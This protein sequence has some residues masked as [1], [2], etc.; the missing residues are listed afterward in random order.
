MLLPKRRKKLFRQSETNRIPGA[1]VYSCFCG[2][3][4]VQTILLYQFM[5]LKKEIR[6][7]L[8][9]RSRD[10]GIL[11]FFYLFLLSTA[12]IDLFSKL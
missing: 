7:K 12:C 9:L 8:L 1:I 4:T 10:V 11:P 5:F 6:Y 2:F 3:N